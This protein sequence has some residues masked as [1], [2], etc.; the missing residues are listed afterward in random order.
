MEDKNGVQQVV[1]LLTNIAQAAHQNNDYKEF[2]HR[3]TK[4]LTI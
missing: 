2:S 1:N 4:D 3:I